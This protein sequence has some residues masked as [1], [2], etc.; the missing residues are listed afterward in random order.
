MFAVILV[1]SK[2]YSVTPGS[3]LDVDKLPGNEGD[4]VV[5]D[6]VLMVEDKGKIHIGTPT[7]S[8]K[9]VKAKIVHQGKGKKIDVSRYKSKVRHRRHIGFRPHL[10]KLEIL[11]IG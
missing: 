5:F 3:V 4:V 10:T 2:Q 7:V 8:G 9:T 1:D 11:S 6:R